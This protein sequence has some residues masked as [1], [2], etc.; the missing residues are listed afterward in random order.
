MSHIFATSASVVRHVSA[1]LRA[2]FATPERPPLDYPFVASD[3]AQLHRIRAKADT[4]SLDDQTWNDLLLEPYLDELSRETSI[5]GKQELYRRLRAGVRAGER[6]AQR[7]RVEALV[8]DPERVARL[9]R[10][11]RPLR[12]ADTEAASLLHEGACPPI[13]AWAGRTWPLPLALMASIAAVALTPFAWLGVAFVLYLLIAT[14]VRYYE[15]VQKWNRS[16]AVLQMMLASCTRLGAD[17]ALDGGSFARGREQA[18]R[19]NRALSRSAAGKAIPGYEEYRDWFALA[20]VNHYL[21]GVQLVFAQRDFLVACHER[22][23]VLEADVALARHLLAAPRWCWAGPAGDKELALDG[24][25]HPLLSGAAPLSITLAGKGAFVS[26]Q[27]GVGKSTFLR[28]VGLSLV[29]ARAFGYAYAREARMPDLR[30]YASMQNEDSLLGGESL[31][32]AELRRARELLAAAESGQP[33]VYLIDE[34]FRGTNHVES[35]SAAAA[36]LDTLGARGLV[37]VSSHN[38][39]LASLLARW[40]EPVQIARAE[41]GLAVRPGVLVETNGV[42]LLAA[43]GFAPEI[44]EK[45]ARVAQWLGKRLAEPAGEFAV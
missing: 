1:H 32:I 5:F 9:H 23:A 41:A 43:Q 13:P 16:V 40:L 33:A 39:V 11:L 14:Q 2:A 18:S 35:V 27:N 31:Y 24:A 7:T 19:I 8:A 34:I 6:A 22:C 42:S 44:G 30:V 29:T 36:V 17:E 3:V 25:V 28:T 20:N 10:S 45:A 12:D 4:P 26:G 15:R 21:K 38:V 37:L